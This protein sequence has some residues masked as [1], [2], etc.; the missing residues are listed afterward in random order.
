MGMRALLC[1]P[2][3]A[4]A[5]AAGEPTQTFKDGKFTDSWWNASYE[6]PG[7]QEGSSA[8]RG[9]TKLFDGKCAGDVSVEITIMPLEREMAPSE[10]KL[11]REKEWA[12]RKREMADVEK[13]DQP[14]L[15]TTFSEKSL[16]G[17]NRHHGYAWYVRGHHCFEVHATAPEKNEASGGQLKAA[18]A[19]FK[20][21]EDTNGAALAIVQ[22][23][24]NL[25]KPM[26]DP[27]VLFAA[28]LSYANPQVQNY[29]L[30]ISVLRRAEKKADALEAK[31]QPQLHDTLGLS[32]LVERQMD[33]AIE[34]LKK[35]EELGRKTEGFP[36]WNCCYNLACA[37]SLHGKM[38]EAFD[39]LTR[40]Y[41]GPER[42]VTDEHISQD[43]D[44]DNMRK[45]ARWENFWRT[46]VKGEKPPA[47]N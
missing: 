40:S 23:A 38:D 19:G 8:A 11:L 42:P 39:A 32:L 4:I 35:A 2:L 30:A 18:L 12:Q 3:L 37:Y 27:M 33:A 15:W 14:T 5:A 24:K 47:G 41:S 28:G 1:I 7:L 29:K 13:G 31:F 10:W 43:T 6:A 26:D 36:W 22:A 9:L 20:A 25:Q 34:S 21:G 16:A 44:L 17:F 45:D 46:V